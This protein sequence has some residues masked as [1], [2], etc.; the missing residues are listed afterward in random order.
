MSNFYQY[1]D[2]FKGIG[3]YRLI[4]EIHDLKILTDVV[5]NVEYVFDEIKLW[6]IILIGPQNSP[7][8]GGKFL[9]HMD[10][11]DRYPFKAPEIRLKTKIYHPL[12]E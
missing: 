10:F 12:V 1:G 8:E 5:E 9:L 2:G 11:S 6:K 7:Y 4:K 3:I